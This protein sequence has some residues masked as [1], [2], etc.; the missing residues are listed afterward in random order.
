[1]LLF[2]VNMVDNVM[3]SAM[4]IRVRVGM[5]I[6]VDFANVNIYFIFT[7]NVTKCFRV[8]SWPQSYGNCAYN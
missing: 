6:R 5:D 3:Y 4:V 2:L 1:M 7:S 8:S